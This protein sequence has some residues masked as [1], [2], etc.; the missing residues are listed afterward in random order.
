MHK[1]G[2]VK[3]LLALSGASLLGGCYQATEL[4][5]PQPMTM[6]IP[7]LKGDAA[8]IIADTK[9]EIP[10]VKSENL[11]EL[12]KRA[13]NHNEQLSAAILQTRIARLQ[14]NIQAG[15]RMPDI[16]ASL[17]LQAQGRSGAL[18]ES[19][20]AA[21]G[22]T[23]YEID[24]F[25]RLK[26]KEAAALAQVNISDAD[27]DAIRLA[28]IHDAI[29]AY[30]GYIKASEQAQI[31]DSIA[32]SAQSQLSI[33]EKRVDL[34]LVPEKDREDARALLYQA[35]ADGELYRKL[36]MDAEYN[37]K[38]ITGGD[39]SIDYDEGWDRIIA[40][41]AG[42]ITTETLTYRPDMKAAE[43][44]LRMAEAN[45]E[46]AQAALLPKLTLTGQGRMSST[47]LKSLLTGSVVWDLMPQLNI[48]IFNSGRLKNELDIQVLRQH[49]AVANYEAVVKT[50]LIETGRAIDATDYVNS[51]LDAIESRIRALEEGL[52][53]ARAQYDAGILD[54]LQVLRS[55][56]QLYA[57]KIRLVNLKYQSTSI[58]AS[59]NKQLGR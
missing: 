3:M 35:K 39:V 11:Q 34:G 28:L 53:I 41:P 26:S 52:R 19:Y 12:I 51:E 46:A 9:N 59:L 15:E 16:G 54:Y 6:A 7:Q 55:E 38:W 23:A 49:E 31:A 8:D 18:D 24:L 27:K 13:L 47:E 44:A 48:P 56:E 40:P 21:L 25:S 4:A 37:L 57:A 58:L 22:T 42:A 29:Q 10:Y 1:Q 50:A 17:S 33:I 30:L 43:W 14:A 5:K 36:L 45:V 32:V 2:C 20:G